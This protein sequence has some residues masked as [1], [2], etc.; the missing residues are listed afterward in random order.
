MVVNCTRDFE[1]RIQNN[2]EITCVDEEAYLNEI[3]TYQLQFEGYTYDQLTGKLVGVPVTALQKF[4]HVQATP[5]A[6]SFRSEPIV[7]TNEE[8]E[9]I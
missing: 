6:T 7:I 1:E 2:L 3:V 5:I 8:L 4:S 9:P